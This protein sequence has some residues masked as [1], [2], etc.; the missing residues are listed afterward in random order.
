[1][2]PRAN[3]K[4]YL[5]LSLVSCPIALYPATSEREKIRFHQVNR[6][7]GNRIK[8][9]RVD[10]ETG[11]EVAYEDIVK[12]YEVA[13]GHNIEIADEELESVEVESSRA[14][15]IDSFVPK[16]EI[17]PL[18]NVRPYYI[19]PDGEVGVQ[20]FA[21]I[22]EAIEK[23]GMVAL[24]RVVLST[25]EH[26]IALEPRGKG[27]MG[28][29]LRYPYEVRDEKDYFDD[30]PDEKIPKDMLDLAVHIVR[31]KKGHF[32]PEKFEDRYETALRELVKK[33]AAGEKIEP[34]KHHEPAKVINLM[35]ALR[36][37]LGR[38]AGRAEAKP[39]KSAASRKPA[40][41]A[42]PPARRRKAG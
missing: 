16:A 8:M 1:M 28:T 15:E 24:G 6:N 18:Y 37:S 2:P 33:K 5:R 21:V 30:I 25:R 11:E 7:T 26:V 20:A 17:D 10:A 27:I 4:G 3:W 9:Q 42:K 31:S 14:I 34:V 19:A 39:R 23:E 38:E 13:K 40:R 36:R 12:G 29:L 32:Q 35:D 22:R 41:K